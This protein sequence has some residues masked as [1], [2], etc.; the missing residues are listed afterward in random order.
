MANNLVDSISKKDDL[1]RAWKAVLLQGKHKI[2]SD[3]SDDL[4][5]FENNIPVLRGLSS[6]G[7]ASRRRSSRLKMRPHSTLWRPDGSIESDDFY[8]PGTDNDWV[9]QKRKG[10]KGE[11]V[12]KR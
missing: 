5:D 12:R 6:R 9:K 11:E 1:F 3:A 4:V 7:T 10:G 2:I 8:R